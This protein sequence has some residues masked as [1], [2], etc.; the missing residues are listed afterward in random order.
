M[1]GSLKI[2]TAITLSAL[3][4]ACGGGSSGGESTDTPQADSGSN[5]GSD[6]GTNG[7]NSDTGEYTFNPANPLATLV[8]G[9]SEYAEGTLELE[10]TDS[11]SPGFQASTIEGQY[12]S[13]KLYDSGNWEYQLN[14]NTSSL[15]NGQSVEDTISIQLT[16]GDQHSITFAIQTIEATENSIVFIL[17]N[18]SDAA[19]TDDVSISQLANMTFNDTDSLDNTYKENS[20]GQL[21]FKRHLISD[22]SLAQYC[23]GEDNNESSS[24]D[25]FVYS[26]PDS[27]SGGVLS[28]GNAQARSGS[29]QDGQY[30]DGGY[31]WRDN[32]TTWIQNN[33]V[34]SNSRPVNLNDWRH[35]V[36]I[37]PRA[38]N[39]AGLV[40]TGV[41]SVRGGWSIITADTDQL[42]MGHE[43]GH[44]IGLSHAGNDDN[45][46][47]DTNDQGESEYGANGAFMGNSWKSR[48]F[49]S[50]HREFMGW[51]E[52]FPGYTT[53]IRQ[54]AGNNADYVV[55]AVE[56]TAGELNSS[57]PQ[58]LKVESN[59]STNGENHYYVEYHIP[60][61]VLNPYPHH[62]NA[63]TIHY[64]N[65]GTANQ[66][67]TLTTTGD[68]FSDSSAGVTIELKSKD[69]SNN[70]ATIAVNYSN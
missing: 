9:T 33:F 42:V 19:V 25:C 21:K 62:A 68:Q 23:Y 26:I 22:Q 35:R 10:G 57:L 46:D 59:G 52:S 49:G 64:L 56:L 3:L 4:A 16:N 13:F 54:S 5:T 30:S 29:S 61:N 31:T 60:H 43:L 44:N 63:V 34:D 38:A 69:S 53:T 18:F 39:N 50:A 58:L 65:D 28:V 55:Q 24:I 40:G 51:Y 11:K 27:Q 37:F 15:N 2:F 6:T 20:F 67:A 12:G 1:H 36:F 32:A 47:G 45:N 14:S 8:V 17:M 48:L 7:G 70:S 66:V 41:A